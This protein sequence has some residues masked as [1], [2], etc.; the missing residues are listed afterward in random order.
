VAR[1]LILPLP[2]E[3]STIVPH[4]LGEPLI[5]ESGERDFL[6]QRHIQ[7]TLS[8]ANA[9]ISLQRRQGIADSHLQFGGAE[10]GPTACRLRFAGSSDYL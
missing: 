2:E 7:Q 4:R 5:P 8:L 3:V 10:M 9:K 1:S 6:P